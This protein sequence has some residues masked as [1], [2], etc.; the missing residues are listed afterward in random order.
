MEQYVGVKDIAESLGLKQATVRRWVDQGLMPP[1]VKVNNK[2]LLWPEE[3]IKNWLDSLRVQ[4]RINDDKSNH[5][6]L[7]VTSELP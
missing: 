7:G 5:P 3:E 2:T 1:P 6:G 4:R